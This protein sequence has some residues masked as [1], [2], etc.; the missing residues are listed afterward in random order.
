[1]W[2]PY[3]LNLIMVRG[4]IDA[5]GY[6]GDPAPLSSWATRMKAAHVHA[7]ENLMICNIFLKKGAHYQAGNQP[8]ILSGKGEEE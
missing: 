3:V 7:V 4:L 1:M 6:P 8:V 2:M 5:V